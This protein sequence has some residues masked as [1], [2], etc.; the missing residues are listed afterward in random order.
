MRQQLFHGVNMLTYQVI[1]HGEPPVLR[2]VSPSPP[3]PG[4]VQLDIAACGVNFADLLM[5]SGQ[6]QDL[7]DTP[8][9]LGMEL[10]G[11]ITALG[12]GVTDLS[13]GDRVAVFSGHGGMAQTGCFR[14]ER[15]LPLP[16]TMPFTDAAAFQVA[17]GTSHLVLDHRARLQPGETVLILGAAGGV[18][19]SAIEIAKLMGAR[20]IAVA[21]GR[22]KLDIAKRAGAD[23]LIDS[24]SADVTAQIKALGGA[25]VVYDPVGGNGFKAALR[26]CNPEAR[27]IV[28]GFAS[29]HLPDIPANILLV[30]NISVIGFFWGGYLKFNPTTLRQSQERLLD[31]YMQGKLRPHISHV[32]P[33]EQAQDALELLRSRKSTGKVVITPQPAIPA[34]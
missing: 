23:H 30:K 2:T 13:I 5:V 19:L 31:W 29:G 16:D 11:T 17:Y 9:T 28:I 34:G 14:A 4:Q 10:A 12:P 33:L 20:V 22:S 32:L 1:N 7:P 15:C 27:M 24:D 8:F 6:Y 18:G 21:R 26:A 3:R 25:D